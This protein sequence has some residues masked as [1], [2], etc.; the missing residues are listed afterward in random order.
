MSTLPLSNSSIWASAAAEVG[1]WAAVEDNKA[2]A[3]DNKAAEMDTWSSWIHLDFN[4]R[5]REKQKN[6]MKDK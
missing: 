2:A 6:I 3:V 4:G 1:I 5:Q